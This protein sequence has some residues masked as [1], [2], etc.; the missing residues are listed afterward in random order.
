[1]MVQ[2]LFVW[3][4]KQQ[5]SASPSEGRGGGMMPGKSTTLGMFEKCQLLPPLLTTENTSKSLILQNMYNYENVR[6]S[7]NI[8]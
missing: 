3:L 6:F 2:V 1:M 5:A 4:E 8:L 7:K